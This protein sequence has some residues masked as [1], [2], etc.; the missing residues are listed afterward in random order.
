M[1]IF[2]LTITRTQQKAGIPVPVTDNRGGWF[3]IF[4]SF[5]GAWQKNVTVDFNSV[6]T[7]HAIYAC[8]TLIAS[9][10]AKL[11]VMY[12]QRDDNGIWTETT[13]SAYSPVLRKPNRF[14]NRIQFWENWLLSKLTRGNTY[15]I[16]ERDS[17]G[18]VKALYVLDPNR[19]T[20]MM[21]DDGSVY[22]QLR[23]DNVS[24]IKQ[25]VLVPASEIIHDRWNC[26]YHPLIGTS[27][28]VAC[29]IAA[30]QGMAIQNNQTN[31]FNNRSQ[32][33]GI[34]TAPGAISDETAARLKTAWETNY[35][36]E[37]SGKVAVLGDG[38]KFEPMAMTSQESQVIEQLKWTAEVASSVFHV[39]PYKIG[40]GEIPANTTVQSLNL[41]YFSQALQR[42]IEDAELCLD[43]GL[44]MSEGTGTEFDIDNLLRMDSVSQ[45]DFLDKATGIMKLD[46]QRKRLNLPP[47]PAGG[48]TVYL[49]QQNFS[50]EALAKRDAKEDPFGTGKQAPT[51][52]PQPE[53]KQLP[54]PEKAFDPA[55]AAKAIQDA[56]AA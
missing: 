9:D 47:L 15:V 55:R 11:R 48:D 37:N 20:P 1:K 32:P 33:G 12:V 16:K 18:V 42:L 23:A 30:T 34:L 19:V 14:Q 39:P 7:F 24:G 28:I 27:P 17:R 50:V 49:Q 10:I 40:V 46:E 36:G 51:Q 21:T 25:D 8:I 38:L 52:L 6:L 29:G 43:E 35:T 13:N 31:F 41:E 5:T 4:E 22:Y 45:I 26:L 44:G 3:R 2:G 53:P 56:L 54:P